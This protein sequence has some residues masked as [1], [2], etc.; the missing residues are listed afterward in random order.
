MP[1]PF[2]NGFLVH[3]PISRHLRFGWVGLQ[4]IP[5]HKEQSRIGSVDLSIAVVCRLQ[6]HQDVGVRCRRNA[7]VW[8][9]TIQVRPGP[10]SCLRSFSEASKLEAKGLHFLRWKSHLVRHGSRWMRGG[11]VRYFD[12]IWDMC[13]GTYK[14]YQILVRRNRTQSISCTVGKRYVHY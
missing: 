13:D 14:K 10:C 11:I 5:H 9:E 12:W 6:I 3:F 7:I 8:M 4:P 2:P 1:I